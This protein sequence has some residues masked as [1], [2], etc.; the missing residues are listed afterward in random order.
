MSKKLPQ[1]II[2]IYGT[3]RQFKATK[4][5]EMGFVMMEFAEFTAGC[6]FIPGYNEHCETIQTHLKAWREEMLVKQWGR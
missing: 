1:H 6:A 4:R 2:Q 3:A 5:K